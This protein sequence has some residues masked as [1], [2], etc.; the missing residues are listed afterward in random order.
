M[1]AFV[2]KDF[3]YFFVGFE[4]LNIIASF[5]TCNEFHLCTALKTKTHLFDLFC[6]IKILFIRPSKICFSLRPQKIWEERYTENN[7][8][9]IR[10]AFIFLGPKGLFV[11]CM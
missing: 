9:L 11:L 3:N 7:I 5:Q 1:L 10:A 4:G 8:R 2:L 6:G